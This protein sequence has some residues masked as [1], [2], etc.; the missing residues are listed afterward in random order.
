MEA[1]AAYL[2][3]IG[4]A[5]IFDRSS[6]GKIAVA[7]GDRRTY[8]HA[9]LTN[10]IE[11]LAAGSGCYA[12]YLTQQGRM[13]ADMR[14][15]ELGDLVLLDLDE[16]VAPAVLQKL[17]QFVFSEDVQLGDLGA[18]F[19]KLSIAGPSAARIVAA[20][21]AADA[22]SDEA[23]LAGWAEFRNA[24]LSFRGRMVLVA[25]SHDLGGAGFDLYLERADA[26]ALWSALVE[27]GAVPGD[28]ET[29]DLLRIE[30][31]RPVFG[32][33]MDADTIPLEAGI[34]GRAISFTKGCYPGQEVVIRVLHR[35]QGRVARKIVALRVDGT[36]VPGP[37][38]AARAVERE[39]G[40]ITSAAWSPRANGVIALAMLHRDFVEAGTA[41]LVHHAGQDLRA[42]VTTVPFVS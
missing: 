31:G 6:R 17:D 27:A 24:R 19:S 28:D 39:A 5:A 37:G 3:A 21:L 34:E 10:D 16:E 2:A 29:A 15:L 8:L 12:A 1:S 13:I 36:T 7:G 14:V 41:L 32:V 11:S 42:T 22:G 20:T 4:T 9:M 30:S 40:R 33:D 38:D 23:S 26:A 25:A 18:A 35:G